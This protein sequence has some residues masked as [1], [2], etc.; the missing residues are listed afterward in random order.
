MATKTWA[1][2]SGNWSTPTLWQ[3][4]IA[5]AAADIATIGSS[6]GTD[7][8]ILNDTETVGGIVLNG[9][10]A[11]VDLTGLLNLGGQFNAQSGTLVVSG[12][13]QGGTLAQNGATIQFTDLDPVTEQVVAPELVNVDVTGTLDLSGSS[14]VLDVI[15][16]AQSGVAAIKIGAGSELMVLDEETFT[17]ETIDLAGGV[18]A[19]DAADPNNGFITIGIG[20]EVLQNTASTT[21]R[22][23]AD[24]V[25]ALLGLGSVVNHGTIIANA[26]T[27]LLD[28]EGGSFTSEFG[29]GAFTNAGTIE[30]GAGATVVDD[31]NAT[32]AGLGTIL[33]AGGLLDLRGTLTNTGTT[34]DVGT[35]GAF[36]ELQLDGM[37][38]GGTILEAGGSLSVGTASLQHVTVVGTGVAFDTL[39]IGPNTVFNPAG[40]RFL[41]T[42]QQAAYGQIFL[43]N[44][45]VLTN[46][47]IAYGG[48]QYEVQIAVAGDGVSA[49]GTVLSGIVPSAT[50]A[51]TTT[52]DVGAGQI[53]LLDGGD[54]TLVNDAVINV[55][56]GGILRFGNAATYV[57]GGTINVVP[58]SLV[59]LTGSIGLNAITDVVGNGATLGNIGNLDLHGG[60][61]STTGNAHFSKFESSGGI[62]D[63]TVIT[64]FTENPNLGVIYDATLVLTGGVTPVNS[65]SVNDTTIRGALQLT[66]NGEIDVYGNLNLENEAGT[67]PG[68][69]ILDQQPVL[70]VLGSATSV[71]FKQSVTV[72]N[73]TVLLSGV[74]PAAETAAF[75]SMSDLEVQGYATVTFA[76]SVQIIATTVNGPIGILGGPGYFVNEGTI[77]VTPGADLVLG[78]Y[79]P[80]PSG[81]PILEDFINTGLIT[82]A[83]GGTLDV[84]TQSSILAL[85]SIVG[86]GGLLRLDAPDSGPNNYDNTGNTLVVGG[87]T[88]APDLLINA[89]TLTGG[90]I[91]NAGG[92]FTALTGILN[93]VTYVGAL[94]LTS[95]IDLLGNT[96]AGYLAFNGGTLI[97]QSVTLAGATLVLGA[98]QSFTGATLS[99]SGEL[100]DTGHTLSFDAHTSVNLTGGVYMPV[101]HFLNAGTITI[102]PGTSLQLDDFSAG[103]PEPSESGTIVVY[104]GAF[105]ANVLDSGQIL[106]LGPN[107]SVNISRFDPGSQVVFQAPN[108]LDIN[109]GAVTNGSFAD[110]GV[111][112]TI[113]LTGY[114]DGPFAQQIFGNNGIPHGS[115]P[116]ITFDY[117]GQTLAV[118]RGGTL[119]IATLTVG[120]GYELGGFTGTPIGT[121]SVLVTGYD[122]TYAPPG[123]P[124]PAGPSITGTQANQATN[125]L[126]AV[127]PFTNVVLSD[128]NAGADITAQVT[129][130]TYTGTLTAPAVGTLTPSGAIWL[131]TGSPAAVQ[132]ALRGLVYTPIPH[133]AVPGQALNPVFTITVNDQFTSVTDTKTSVLATAVEDPILVSGVIPLEYATDDSGDGQPFKTIALSDPDNTQFTATATLSNT[134]IASFGHSYNST[135]SAGG[136]Y[137]ASGPLSTVQTA[138]QNLIIYAS[139]LGLP[140]GQSETATVTMTISDQISNTATATSTLV[141]VASGTADA[142]GLDFI[143]ATPGQTTTD[144]IAIDPF[145]NAILVDKSVGALDTITITMSNP[146][147]G[148]FSDTLGTITNGS[149]FTATGTVDSVGFVDAIDN[150]LTG[151]VF[152]PTLG[153]VP[154]GQSVTTTFDVVASNNLGTATDDSTS[155]IA[156]AAGGALTISGTQANQELADNGNALPLVG[157]T[158]QDT[159]IAPEDTATVTLS[160]PSSG[161]LAAGN[162]GTVGSNGV[163][164]VSGPLAAV[165]SALQAL[166]FV[167]AAARTGQ[168]IT[169]GLTIGVVD[170]SLTA[171]DKTTSLDV[172]GT[173]GSSVGGTVGPTLNGE[174]VLAFTTEGAALPNTTEVASFTDSSTIDAAGVFTASIDWGDGTTTAGTVSGADGSFIVSGGHTYAEEGSYPLGVTVTDTADPEILPLSGTVTVSD[175]PLL[176]TAVDVVATEGASTGQVA[177]A[178]F[179]DANPDATVTDFTATIDWGDGTS[180][181]GTVEVA[182]GGGF[183]VDG[184]HTYAEAAQY[185]V[186]VSIDDKGGSSAEASGT[187]MVADAPPGPTLSGTLANVG[188]VNETPL[189]PFSA[190][191]VTDTGVGDTDTVAIT[192]ANPAFGTLPNLEGGSYNGTTGAYAVSGTPG[193]VTTAIDGLQITPAIPTANVFL[194]STALTL[195]VT[196]PGGGPAPQNA[197]VASVQQVLNL[198]AVP[199]ANIAISVSADGTGLAAP[200]AH[201]TN[202]A[203]VTSPTTGAIYTLP[204]GYQAEY[205]GGNANA[206]LQDTSVGNAVLVGNTGND[207]LIGAAAGDSIVAG[208]GNNTLEGGSGAVVLD[209]G[210]GNDSITT[211]ANST[212]TVMLGNGADTVFANGT[213]TVT[214]GAGSDLLDAAGTGPSAADLIVSHGLQ[215][216]VLGGA[217]DLAVLDEGTHDTVQGGAG[218]LTVIDDGAHDT[219]QAAGGAT[220][221]TLN[222]SF[223][224]TRGGTGSFTVDAPNASSTVI[225]GTAG[226]MFVTVGAAAANSDVFGRAGNTHILD[227]GADALMG[228]GG[229]TSVVTI[230]GAGTP[231]LWQFPPWRHPRCQHRRGERA[232]V[233]PRRQRDRRCIERSRNQRAGLRRVQ[234][235]RG[236]QWLVVGPGWCGL[237]RRRHRR[238]ERNHQRRDRRVVHVHR[239]RQPRRQ[240]RHQRCQRQPALHGVHRW[241]GQRHGLW[242]RG[243]RL[244]VR[245]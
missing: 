178:T 163:F 183:S 199:V 171:T 96:G 43:N 101:G 206:T 162:G 69:L 6:S 26:G 119:T 154:L 73:A 222:G 208:N 46:A 140:T 105:D 88:G 74:T 170:G 136:V 150:A 198:A 225:G 128:P 207:V 223:G 19:S 86:P 131:D 57:P 177:V 244:G 231:A 210:N 38:L 102:G 144:H 99:L 127:A 84:L 141:I 83:A 107:S 1:G 41:L 217:G 125:D 204:A 21:A 185:S 151:L 137:S 109:Q 122:I 24:V 65:L 3:G 166:V 37:V 33:N 145:G 29:L 211:A 55:A 58:D 205:L 66:A 165:Q 31:T 2:T 68:V 106:D 233:R 82:I 192:L 221:V 174:I 16:L 4:A 228:A 117:D 173:G 182:G 34:V 215:G 80:T 133:L 135:I 93:D 67:G 201:H 245:R 159:Q 155:V 160:N 189:T 78:P 188:V 70:Y 104:G 98:D 200:I 100:A 149:T 91:V 56:A 219:I 95:G 49:S 51:S 62:T 234:Q 239:D 164:H 124:A 139:P 142:A 153:Q 169:T 123:Q 172:I 23:G 229:G 161:A 168:M 193:V 143:G 12:T 138:L 243:W 90:T 203:A 9:T 17:G 121:P 157:V 40:G 238:F 15:G 10:N 220:S 176:A 186:G 240:Q 218:T 60:T 71:Q 235:H 72:T 236:G 111:G 224:R 116:T 7:T 64:N 97:S 226:T 28:A 8:I 232:G 18:L 120:A 242:R 81:S 209:A 132:A 59:E 113:A 75:N 196:G 180:S 134:S 79:G 103:T 11:V 227:L 53:L 63:G 216:T 50:L 22:I 147:N 197:I 214:G 42:A 156:T 187:A 44:G 47:A 76:P 108:T 194:T 126:T 39:T 32:F 175:A 48:T 114:E 212:Y 110:F 92:R 179:T 118:I 5:P 230:D 129:Y 184:A 14:T 87:S 115:D 237:A 202:E 61:I 30:I 27:L 77:A 195:T 25:S 94:D 35:T 52:L 148:V 213:G 13:L 85:G 36:R 54:G 112:D 181:A 130:P 146:A 241:R 89:T 191:T 20:T 158:I 167:P 152:T 45:A 190:L